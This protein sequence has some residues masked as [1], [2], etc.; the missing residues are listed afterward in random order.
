MPGVGFV[1]SIAVVSIGLAF[2]DSA[3]ALLAIVCVLVA[4]FVGL[5]LTV[6]EH[7]SAR[8]HDLLETPFLLS[9]DVE[10]F[11]QYRAIASA[12]LRFSQNRDPVF[13]ETAS[14]KLQILTEQLE[15]LA[16]GTIVFPETETWRM[17]Y[18]KLLRTRGLYRYRSVA[19]VR[20]PGYWQDEPGRRSTRVNLEIVERSGVTVERIVILANELWPDHNHLPDERI[21]QWI[22]EQSSYG[23]DVRL[24][25]ES[26]LHSESDLITD[27]GIYGSRAVGFQQLDDQ[28]RTVRFTLR[29][30][31]DAIN[32]AEA[33]WD[34]LCI[35]AEKYQEI[36]DRYAL[37]E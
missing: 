18:E 26:D 29:F 23:V 4:G 37:Y 24:V 31:I 21:R 25:R 12:L 13:R 16:N 15:E 11:S 19:W 22:H 9:H 17:A 30:D 2:A 7:R 20:N 14:G 8:H 3:A 35:Y 10:V 33:R 1:V 6:I 32:A 27:M 28:S 34:R 36:L 5:S